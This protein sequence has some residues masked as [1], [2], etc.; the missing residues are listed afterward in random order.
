MA[1]RLKQMTSRAYDNP[2]GGDWQG[3]GKNEGSG[4]TDPSQGRFATGALIAL[5]REASKQL[6]ASRD[7]A[8]LREF[9][10]DAFARAEPTT[11]V[12][13]A[14]QWSD[15]ERLFDRY[16]GD[17]TMGPALKQCFTGG[18]SLCNTDDLGVAMVR[19]D[20]VPH[21]ATA[22]AQFPVEAIDQELTPARADVAR[23]VL[24]QVTAF[25]QYAARQRAAVVF[26]H[27]T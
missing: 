8:L 23:D 15:L 9:L 16:S 2:A 22:L 17:P 10:L 11:W 24:S 3:N 18:R 14:N 4:M 20:L 21:A 1:S 6:F 5:D 26:V 13:C 27:G 7:P 12:D 19:P 25:Y